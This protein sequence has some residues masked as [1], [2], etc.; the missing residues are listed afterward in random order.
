MLDCAEHDGNFVIIFPCDSKTDTHTD[1]LEEEEKKVRF[2][3]YDILS[4]LSAVQHTSTDNNANR[5][6]FMSDK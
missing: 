3:I 6:T 5:K 2:V 1:S 4:L